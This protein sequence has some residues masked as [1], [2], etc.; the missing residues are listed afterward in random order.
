MRRETLKTEFSGIV[1]QQDVRK[2]EID[3]V[4]M[5]ESFVPGDVVRCKVLAMGEGRS[6]V[7][8]DER[9]SIRGRSGEV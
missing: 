7:F 5:E 4:I 1:R 8:S 9:K 3:K 6:L 2:T